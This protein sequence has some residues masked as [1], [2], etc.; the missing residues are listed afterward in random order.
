M[1]FLLAG[2][3]YTDVPC[4]LTHIDSTAGESATN[5]DSSL[6][7]PALMHF[8]FF[9]YFFLVLFNTIPFCNSRNFS[10]SSQTS[11]VIVLTRHPQPTC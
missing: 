2:V 9:L 5:A 10:I 6:V 8:L 3:T 7:V 4:D 1:L 11:I